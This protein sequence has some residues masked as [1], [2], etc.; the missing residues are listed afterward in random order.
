MI[1]IFFP[2][3]LLTFYYLKLQ[4]GFGTVMLLDVVVGASFISWVVYKKVKR[5][6]IRIPF[7]DNRLLGAGVVLFALGIFF[8]TIQS[9]A[10]F[11]AVG[12]VKSW[13]LVPLLFYSMLYDLFTERGERAKEQ[14][15]MVY[16]ATAALTAC[17][18]LFSYTTTYDSRLTYF[19]NPNYLA[20][21]LAPACV[22]ALWG[23][24]SFKKPKQRWFYGITCGAISLPLFLT[25]SYSAW[26]GVLIADAIILRSFSS[27]RGWKNALWVAGAATALLFLLNQDKFLNLFQERSSLLSRIEIWK[28]A[29]SIFWSSQGLGIGFGGFEGAYLAVQRLFPPYLHWAVLHAHNTFIHVLVEAGFLGFLGFIIIIWSLIT[30]K[31]PFAVRLLV[32]GFIVYFCCNSLFDTLYFKNDLALVFWMFVALAAT[33]TDPSGTNI[34]PLYSQRK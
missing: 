12:R 1:F 3:I 20:F 32:Y 33:T 22:A 21:F 10:V 29:F 2:I 31:A 27:K 30:T 13:F 26:F 9:E 24:L 25:F 8:A 7:F 17:V 11:S 5:R 14:T 18:A 34:R 6:S 15:I 19:G 16:V 28:A 23:F 4:T